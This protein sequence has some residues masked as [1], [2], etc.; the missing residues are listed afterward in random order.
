MITITEEFAVPS[1]PARVWAV[2]SN[3]ADVVSCI[4]GAELGAA[5]EDGSFDGTL[6]VKFGALRVRF[7][8]RVLLELAGTEREGRLS[9]RGR[10]G[11]GATR[12]SGDAT[13]RVVEDGTPDSSLVSVRGE[14]GL[15]GKLASLI[16][17]G[18]GVVVSRMTKEFSAA[19]IQRCAGPEVPAPP[20]PARTGWLRRC[21]AWLARL[22][23]RRQAPVPHREEV[24]GG[25]VQAQ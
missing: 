14:I 20:G 4:D 19:L 6:V 25:N 18:A 8:A 1:P 15:T 24:G 22:L 7:G 16:E 21:R 12:F 10:D 13:F 3:P 9:A 11:Q 5:H 23:P 2:V 17:S